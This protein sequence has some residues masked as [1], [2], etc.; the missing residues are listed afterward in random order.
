[1]FCFVLL[2]WLRYLK[3][4]LIPLLFGYWKTQSQIYRVHWQI[5]LILSFWASFSSLHFYLSLVSSC[6]CPFSVLSLP[7]MKEHKKEGKQKGRNRRRRERSKE[8]GREEKRNKNINENQRI[9]KGTIYLYARLLI[10]FRACFSF[11][12]RL[13][14]SWCLIRT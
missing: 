1:M 13:T 12:I 4:S 6:F 11:I 2:L 3:Y 9:R 14:H 8:E 7:E 10:R 5:Y